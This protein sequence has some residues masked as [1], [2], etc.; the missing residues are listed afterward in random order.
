MLISTLLSACFFC[1]ILDNCCL[2][3]VREGRKLFL[4]RILRLLDK[5]WFLA[6]LVKPRWF[7]LVWKCQCIQHN[8]AVVILSV[9]KCCNEMSVFSLSLYL[10]A[11]NSRLFTFYFIP[12]WDEMYCLWFF[13]LLLVRV[14]YTNILVCERNGVRIFISLYP[15]RFS[16]T[17]LNVVC[18]CFTN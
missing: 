10:G 4:F 11:R 13:T 14:I 12:P 18:Y 1:K 5:M 3:K 2:T 6:I 8:F 9:C 7:L 15:V 17:F 16:V